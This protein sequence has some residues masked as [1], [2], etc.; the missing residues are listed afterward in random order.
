VNYGSLAYQEMF[1]EW[2]KGLQDPG[3]AVLYSQESIRA[4]GVGYLE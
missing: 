4:N 3:D 1:F 2:M